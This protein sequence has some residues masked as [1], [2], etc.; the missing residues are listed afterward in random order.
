[1]SK[2]IMDEKEVKEILKIDD[3][4]KMSKNKI[5]EFVSMLPKMDKEVA[6]ASI[7][8]FPNY[9]VMAKE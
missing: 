9:A 1:M 2:K 7:N 3:F 5:V 8:K 6:L 4:R